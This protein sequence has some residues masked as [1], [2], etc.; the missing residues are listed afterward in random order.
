MAPCSLREVNVRVLGSRFDG[1][2]LLYFA[3]DMHMHAFNNPINQSIKI[4]LAKR[5]KRLGSTFEMIAMNNGGCQ[6]IENH[7]EIEGVYCDDAR[8]MNASQLIASTCLTDV[9]SS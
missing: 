8:F 1:L 4:I 5:E 3:V 2:F 7:Y 9:D 6:C